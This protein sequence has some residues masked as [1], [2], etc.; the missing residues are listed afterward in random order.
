MMCCLFAPKFQ[1]LS[2]FGPFEKTVASVGDGLNLR[3][4]SV[5]NLAYFRPARSNL[6]QKEAK[7]RFSHW[8][9]L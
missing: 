6:A 3:C 4:Q 2:A 9:L 1:S 8:L 5:Y 7:E